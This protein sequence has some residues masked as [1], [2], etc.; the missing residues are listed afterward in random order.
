MPLMLAVRA[1]ETMA[2]APCAAPPQRYTAPYQT[3]VS[4]SRLRLRNRYTHATR[5]ARTEHPSDRARTCSPQ[6]AACRPDVD[7]VVVQRRLGARQPHGVRL[8][9]G[10]GGPDGGLPGRG[11]ALPARHL[12]AR[13]LLR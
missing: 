4:P 1:G 10:G 11:D 6:V 7:P 9:P 12:P 2:L 5:A 13:P 3:A 8:R